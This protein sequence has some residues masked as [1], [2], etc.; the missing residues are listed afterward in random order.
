MS[1]EWGPQEAGSTADLSLRDFSGTP[2]RDSEQACPTVDCE[3]IARAYDLSEDQVR[4]YAELV[5]E[6]A[7]EM[8]EGET[9]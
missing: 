5:Q 9:E 4:S 1:S 7:A 2:I 3:W 8:R 6:R